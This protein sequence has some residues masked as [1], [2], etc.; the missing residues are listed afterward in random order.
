MDI[1][2]TI[3]E[4]EDGR[5]YILDPWQNHFTKP[6]KYR[7]AWPTGLSATEY[8]HLIGKNCVAKGTGLYLV[9]GGIYVAL[10]HRDKTMPSAEF[11]E[12]RIISKPPWCHMY[13]NGRWT[14]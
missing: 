4:R 1:Q 13:Y 9:D 7:T 11:S 5:L 8:P 2:S 6:I 3:V 12:E 14:R 10:E